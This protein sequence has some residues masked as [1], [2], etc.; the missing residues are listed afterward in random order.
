MSVVELI[1]DLPEIPTSE[2]FSEEA[3][4]TALSDAYAARIELLVKFIE[5]CSGAIAYCGRTREQ[6]KVVEACSI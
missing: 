4:Y 3:F 2:H 6:E 5:S 1:A